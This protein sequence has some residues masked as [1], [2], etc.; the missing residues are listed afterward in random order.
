MVMPRSRSISMESSTC[1]LPA[2]SR[3]DRPPVIWIRRSASVDFPWSI[4]ATMEK[5]RMLGMGA[6]VMGRG[7]AFVLL[8]GNQNG[9]VLR[10]SLHAKLIPLPGKTRYACRYAHRLIHARDD[11]PPPID[12]PADRRVAGL[13]R[14]EPPDRLLARH[15]LR[16][17]ARPALDENP[18]RAEGRAGRSHGCRG[19]LRLGAE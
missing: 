19:S 6:I 2:I 1:S 4:W 16:A 13:A 5:L 15:Y 8:G 7:I 9:R 11:A 14:Y 3:S 10:C 18:D 17:R 12:F